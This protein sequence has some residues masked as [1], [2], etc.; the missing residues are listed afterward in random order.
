MD[1]TAHDKTCER[2]F[3]DICV[4]VS[5]RSWTTHS[6]C[7]DPPRP[8]SVSWGGKKDRN[9]IQPD[10]EQIQ[11]ADICGH[12]FNHHWRL[13]ETCFACSSCPVELGCFN[14]GC[15]LK[16]CPPLFPEEANSD[17]LSDN[18]ADFKIKV[19]TYSSGLVGLVFKIF[20]PES[21]LCLKH[22]GILGCTALIC[23]S[24]MKSPDLSGHQALV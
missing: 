14:L 16:P 6:V 2:S 18:T 19:C 20:R 15:K 12:S 21:D 10:S 8:S 22:Y 23:F 4:A 13:Q 7:E 11:H 5:L 17:R 9:S 1:H 24:A 3:G